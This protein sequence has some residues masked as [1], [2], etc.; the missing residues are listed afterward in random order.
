MAMMH[1]PAH[2]GKILANYVEGHTVG[3][4]AAHLGVTRPA[5]SRILNGHAAISAEM[6][7]RIGKTFDTDPALWIRL[8]GQYDLWHASQREIKAV[9]IT[10]AADRVRRRITGRIEA[11]PD[12]VRTTFA[13]AR[14]Q[15]TP[16]RRTRTTP[17]NRV[18]RR[19]A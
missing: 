9:P 17:K 15:S 16:L 1:N 14:A 10:E 12:V 19:G 6:A 5:L 2:P 8:Q 7:I 11:K 3:D 13:A 4:V 18:S